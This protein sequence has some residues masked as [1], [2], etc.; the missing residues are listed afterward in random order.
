VSLKR[1]YPFN[2]EKRNLRGQKSLSCLGTKSLELEHSIAVK[3]N[4]NVSV[5]FSRISEK[6]NMLATTISILTPSS[7][8]NPPHL[9]P[10][11]TTRVT[12]SP[13]SSKSLS[14]LPLLARLSH[15]I[16]SNGGGPDRAVGP[17]SPVSFNPNHSSILWFPLNFLLYTL[18]VYVCVHEMFICLLFVICL[19]YVW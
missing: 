17:T 1:I 18:F 6:K 4:N 16:N 5:W 9:P 7:N 14:K 10:L 11:T 13:Y 15:S 3:Q 12:L 2:K 19:M 8:L